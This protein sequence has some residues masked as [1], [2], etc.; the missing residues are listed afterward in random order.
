MENNTENVPIKKPR[1]WNP[2]AVYQEYANQVLRDNPQCWGKYSKPAKMKN[3]WIYMTITVK[4]VP[5]VV[6]VINYRRWKAIM[7]AYFESAKQHIIQ[8]GYLTLGERLGYIKARRCERNHAEKRV[9]FLETMK[10]PKVLNAE[11]KMVPEK[12]IL[13]VDDDYIRISWKK[14]RQVHN[15]TFYEFKPTDGDE[16][17]A[18]FSQEFSQ[19]N[20]A[21]PL[22]K[23]KYD[24]YPYI[25]FPQE[26]EQ[27]TENSA[28]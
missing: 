11:G 3:Y 25:R 12:V 5:K 7:V 27:T 24:Y 28:S 26:E 21:D 14:T 6:E 18:G 23:Y 4:E 13:W 16:N 1:M 15:E 2:Q 19:A 8:G 20:M 10:Q 17:K 22:L 9:N